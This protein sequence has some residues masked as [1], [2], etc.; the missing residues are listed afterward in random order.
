MPTRGRVY[1]DLPPWHGAANRPRPVRL[2]EVTDA[3]LAPI[4]RAADSSRLPQTVW[5]SKYY[6]PDF[7][8]ADCLLISVEAIGAGSY[9]CRPSHAAPGSDFL[10]TVLPASYLRR[11]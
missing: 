1:G 11:C 10:F 4:R 7:V 3:M 9:G 6:G 2:E 5:P 8:G